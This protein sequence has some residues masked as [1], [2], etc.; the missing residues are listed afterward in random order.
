M[1][2][3]FNDHEIED[4]ASQFDASAG[5]IEQAVKKAAEIGSDSKDEV[6][7]AILLSLEAH[8]S[9][10]NGGCKPIIAGKINPKSFS[11]EGL[12][13]SGVDLAGLMKELE[14]FSDYLKH[15]RND[16]PVSMSLLFHGV[17]GSGKSHLAR[18][19]AHRLDKEILVKRG[20]DILSSWVG[21]T[22]QN[23]RERLRRSR[24]KRRYLA[25]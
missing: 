17:S 16:E 19:I 2:A 5:V 18:F 24:R 9:L 6:H 13:V 14:S 7:K 8:Q 4:L 12:N 15:S 11:L 22:E 23:I 20:S 10:V 1:N 21:G 25:L 3:Y